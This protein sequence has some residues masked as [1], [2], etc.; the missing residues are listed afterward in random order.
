MRRIIGFVLRVLSRGL[1]LFI[2]V[3]I[4]LGSNILLLTADAVYDT[5]KRGLWSL[6]SVVADVGTPTTHRGNREAV[7]RLTAQTEVF[8]AEAQRLDVELRRARNDVAEL[9]ADNETLNRRAARLAEEKAKLDQNLRRARRKLT[10]LSGETAELTAE[11]ARLSRRLANLEIQVNELDGPLRERVSAINERLARR[12]SRMISTNTSSMA[13]EAVPYVGAAAIVGLT[14]M[15]VRDAC[16][17][18]ADTREM[19]QLLSGEPEAKVPACGY[20]PAEFWDILAGGPDAISCRDLSADMPTELRL[21]CST[22]L[23][24]G[25]PAQ[26][27]S[28]SGPVLENIRRP[29]E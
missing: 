7:V 2:F 14:F 16:L 1:F 24:P 15:E 10:D 11:R 25:E 12:T 20:S 26:L 9:G 23:R 21:D 17:T 6:A 27:N 8:E 5:A 3:V 28:D 19:S 29:G 18:L 4:I 13:I 22:I